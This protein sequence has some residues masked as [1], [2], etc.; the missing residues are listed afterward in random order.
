MYI[1]ILLTNEECLTIR[2]KKIIHLNGTLIFEMSEKDELI[3]QVKPRY[4][5]DEMVYFVLQI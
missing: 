1:I 4:Y 5:F 3:C 2:P